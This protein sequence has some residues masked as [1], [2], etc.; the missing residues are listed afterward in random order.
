MSTHESRAA[1]PAF[2]KCTEELKTVVPEDVKEEFTALAVI[3]G[4]RPSDYL[5]DLVLDH[6]Y[7]RLHA[8]RVRAGR[9]NGTANSGR[10]DGE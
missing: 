4:Q 8:T 9:G 3:N 1:T 5:R 7:G 10:H 2:G 6:L